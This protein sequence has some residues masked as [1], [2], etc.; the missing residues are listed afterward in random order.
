MWQKAKP[1]AMNIDMN[2]WQRYSMPFAIAVLSV[3]PVHA[4]APPPTASPTS[5]AVLRAELLRPFPSD[6]VSLMKPPVRGETTPAR[7][8]LNDRRHDPWLGTDK[9]LHAAFSFLWT[10]SCQYALVNK[11]DRSERRAW[12]PCAGSGAALGLA[13]EIYD[14]TRAP[15]NVFSPRDL[16]A[17][18]V[19]LVLAV[20]VIHL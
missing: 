11:L 3:L 15:R 8:A 5:A 18:A 16:A 1:R 4:Q 2:K 14:G 12:P 7:A 17:D 20:G 19:G 6:V 13:K 9:V 10:L